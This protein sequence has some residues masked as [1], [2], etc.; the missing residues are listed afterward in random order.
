[1]L[2]FVLVGLHSLKATRTIVQ[3]LSWTKK[4]GS[5]QKTPILGLYH[6]MK[7]ITYQV[8]GLSWQRLLEVLFRALYTYMETVHSCGLC[9]PSSLPQSV[10]ARCI[11][12]IQLP[13]F[14]QKQLLIF[15]CTDAPS[16]QE[17][18]KLRSPKLKRNKQFQCLPEHRDE[19]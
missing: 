15:L 12:E 14:H 17:T 3:D 7:S 9:Y 5:C 19:G 8:R 10:M 16:H 1:M 6:L 2:V 18:Q 11:H 4:E 13:L